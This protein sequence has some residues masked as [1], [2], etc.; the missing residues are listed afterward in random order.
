M[1][2]FIIRRLGYG[3]LVVLGVIIVI[4]L[5]FYVLP[6]DPVSTI[7]GGK[8]DKETRD[9]ITRDLGL[10]KPLM[11]QL[12]YYLNDLSPLGIHGTAES[13]RK[14]YNYTPLFSVG[15]DR[16]LVLK[17]P[18][19]GRSYLS[20]RRVDEILLEDIEG[21]LILAIVSMF[22]ATSIGIIFG[23]IAAL[24]QNTWIDYSLVT[25]SVLGISTPSFVLA[26]II[27]IIFG[28]Y[29]A[30]YTGLNITGSLWELNP[31]S[32]KRELYLKNLI[33]PTVTLSLR[34]LSIIVQLT[35]SSMLDVLSQDYIRTARAKGLLF[36]QI[37]IKHALKNALNPV[38]TAVSGWLAS[39]MA[40]AFFIEYIF[41]WKG[42]GRTTIQAVQNLDMPIVMGATIL[43]AF[44]FVIIN[45]IVD[46]LY[47]MIDPRVRLH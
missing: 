47:A 23:I 29:L 1:I 4:F 30:E 12:A 32:G 31:F 14:K 41:N 9:A 39:L 19:M 10:D 2:Y 40:G 28:F 16:V 22:L 24:R 7:M 44:I 18:Y 5:L 37:V 17:N 8:G 42:L 35:R 25:L 21:T 43:I 20:N 45:I 26:I 6:G 38:I 27:S 46:I 36:Y 11:I 15:E 13:I 3:L 33:L 34:P